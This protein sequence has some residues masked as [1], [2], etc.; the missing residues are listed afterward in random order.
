MEKYGCKQ[1]VDIEKMIQRFP[2]LPEQILE[3]L[4]EKEITI[5]L[6]DLNMLLG[7][8]DRRKKYFEPLQRV[9]GNFMVILRFA[10]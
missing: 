9:L 5:S 3:P 6:S 8:K 1:I 4:K 2:F 10:T 7:H